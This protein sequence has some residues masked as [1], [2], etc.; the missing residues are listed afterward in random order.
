MRVFVADLRLVPCLSTREIAP[1]A[2]YLSWL[3]GAGFIRACRWAGF[4]PV[5]QTLVC[6]AHG[7]LVHLR[8]T[9]VAMHSWHRLLGDDVVQERGHVES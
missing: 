2:W 8:Y 7:W 5:G 3:V 9:E 6:L 1:F 4:R